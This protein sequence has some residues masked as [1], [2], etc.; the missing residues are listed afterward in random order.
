[1]LSAFTY[2]IQLPECL[3]KMIWSRLEEALDI[4]I[5]WE[6]F[7][8][9]LQNPSVCI[10]FCAS[11]RKLSTYQGKDF[12]TC[13]KITR[14][15]FWGLIHLYFDKICPSARSLYNYMPHTVGYFLGCMISNN[16]TLKQSHM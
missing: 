16:V 4:I 2:L 5:L 11:K 8:S 7:S 14:L 12:I 1:M 6:T 15:I 13:K 9:L 10:Y 3:H